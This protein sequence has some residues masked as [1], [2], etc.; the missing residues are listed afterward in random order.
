MHRLLALG[1]DLARLRARRT[2]FPLWMELNSETLRP[3]HIALYKS[4]GRDILALTRHLIVSSTLRDL[5]TCPSRPSERFPTPATMVKAT[6]V[7]EGE[8]DRSERCLVMV[9][10]NRGRPFA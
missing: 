7:A 1:S 4:F 10:E 5:T 9:P 8:R 3:A 2:L 6:D